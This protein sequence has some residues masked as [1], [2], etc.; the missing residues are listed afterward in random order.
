MDAVGFAQNPEASPS[1][2][3][4]PNAVAVFVVKNPNAS[5]AFFDP[6]WQV[7]LFDQSGNLLAVSSSGGGNQLP[8]I[9]P[10]SSAAKIVD[11]NVPPQSQIARA[12]VIAGQGPVKE[13][14]GPMPLQVD[15][16]A[17]SAQPIPQVTGAVRNT[18]T[19]DLTMVDLDG[20]PVR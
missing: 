7:A 10:N 14:S 15:N 17:Y 2:A 9:F 13:L 3:L 1:S 6:N 5:Q 20:R 4:N 19:Q 16:V 12:E 8:I 11:L 18:G